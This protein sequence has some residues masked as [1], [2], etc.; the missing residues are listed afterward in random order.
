MAKK[1]AHVNKYGTRDQYNKI[2]TAQKEANRLYKAGVTKVN[3]YKT[4]WKI[5]KNGKATAGSRALKNALADWHEAI[6]HGATIKK[7]TRKEEAQ[8]KAYYKHLGSEGPTVK[9]GRVLIGAGQSLFTKDE[10]RI[11]KSG[12]KQIGKR[13]LMTDGWQDRVRQFAREN[14]DA[15]ILAKQTDLLDKFRSY[16][17]FEMNHFGVEN[18]IAFMEQYESGQKSVTLL[19]DDQIKKQL[20]T[21]LKNWSA[22]QRK[23]S[24]ERKRKQRRK[25]LR[26]GRNG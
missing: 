24:A 16:Q 25:V 5:D 22:F 2:R 23:A 19:A 1:A 15:I 13:I 6:H 20:K 11:E 18:L 17:A 26:N 12:T 7:L 8:L 10:V 3:P 14:P 4:N 9:N 21:N